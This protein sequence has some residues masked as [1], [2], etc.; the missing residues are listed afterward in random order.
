[1]RKDERRLK[2]GKKR[3]KKSRQ[4]QAMKKHEKRWKVVG[5]VGDNMRSDKEKRESWENAFELR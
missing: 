3:K 2:I 5:R 4:D 1:M